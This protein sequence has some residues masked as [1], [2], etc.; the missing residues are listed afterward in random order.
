MP[1]E[2]KTSDVNPAKTCISKLE[3]L[4]KDTYW[5]LICQYEQ[6]VKIYDQKKAALRN[7]WFFIQEFISCVY[8]NQLGQRAHTS[9]RW[10]GRVT[11]S[12]LLMKSRWAPE[13][14]KMSET[15]VFLSFYLVFCCFFWPYP[16]TQ[17][18]DATEPPTSLSIPD[19]RIKQTVDQPLERSRAIYRVEL[20]SKSWGFCVYLAFCCLFWPYSMTR[21]RNTTEPP[22]S[23]QFPTS[24]SIK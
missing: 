15:E 18:R 12:I 11:S 20:S 7:L 22:T 13:N 1:T 2:P 3:D 14:K 8:L 4:E 6:K 17:P 16:T 10:P 21:L 23:L 19:P 9:T 5:M 24:E